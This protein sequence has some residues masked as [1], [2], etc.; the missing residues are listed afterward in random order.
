MVVYCVP[1]KNWA[2]QIKNEDFNKITEFVRDELIKQLLPMSY[3]NG[4][5]VEAVPKAMLLSLPQLV[6]L[7][8][9][10]AATG[11]KK[12]RAKR[13][14]NPDDKGFAKLWAAYPASPNFT[15]RGMKFKGSRALRSNY[16]VCEGKYL[17]ALAAH[18]DL[19]PEMIFKALEKQKRLAFEE[20][21]ETGV[22]KL[23][24]WNGFEVWLHQEKFM[25]FVSVGDD[26]D[27]SS[28]THE[29]GSAGGNNSNYA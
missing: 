21:Y 12:E 20:S 11:E 15:Y 22:N 4:Y 26:E 10:L 24:H 23:N 7:D 9:F 25:A 14:P 5:G 6:T 19:T 29:E 17:K 13:E 16:Q 2:M 1:P 18:K 3:G 28:S 27:F 8:K